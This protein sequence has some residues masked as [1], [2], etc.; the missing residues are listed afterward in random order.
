[1]KFTSL[2]MMSCFFLFLYLPICPKA[3]DYYVDKKWPEYI[4]FPYN[5]KINFIT[6]NYLNLVTKSEGEVLLRRFTSSF[7][8]KKH[9][10]SRLRHI[11][12]ILFAILVN[13][14]NRDNRKISLNEVIGY[15]YVIC[16]VRNGSFPKL[17]TVILN[18]NKYVYIL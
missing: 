17:T 11:I 2:S 12:T 3:R 7:W 18:L 9:L 5:A 15:I 14:F 1:M 4:E 10:A 16:G 13:D 6:T 8:L